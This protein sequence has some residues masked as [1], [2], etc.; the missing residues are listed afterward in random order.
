MGTTR[1]FLF[2]T[3]V[4]Y[5]AVT[6]VKVSTYFDLTLILFLL[7]VFMSLRRSNSTEEENG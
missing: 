6:L 4:I 3:F 2:L 7:T 1:Q 5:C